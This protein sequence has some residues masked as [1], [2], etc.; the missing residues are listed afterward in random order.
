MEAV[1]SHD[2]VLSSEI[3][4]PRPLRT[5]SYVGLRRRKTQAGYQHVTSPIFPLL[6]GFFVPAKREKLKV[7]VVKG[8]VVHSIPSLLC[9]TSL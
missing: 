7:G 9:V 6:Y 2:R 4:R 5:S 3:S 1:K 8:K